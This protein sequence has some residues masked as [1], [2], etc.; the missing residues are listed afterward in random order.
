MGF[1]CGVLWFFFII[2]LIIDGEV[3]YILKDMNENI[4]NVIVDWWFDYII[5]SKKYEKC[6]IYWYVYL[7]VYKMFILKSFVDFSCLWLNMNILVL[8]RMCFVWN[9]IN[10]DG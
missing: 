10:G 7:Y 5:F 8:D 4:D 6:D 2:S 3:F 9:R 1:F